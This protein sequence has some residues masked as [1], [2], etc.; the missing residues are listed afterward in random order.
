M[1]K[2]QQKLHRR[3]DR[4][5]IAILIIYLGALTYF[6]AF[7]YLATED[8][9][10]LSAVDFIAQGRLIGRSTG[11]PYTPL[12]GYLYYWYSLGFGASVLGLRLLTGFLVVAAAIPIYL[13]LR[14]ISG[15]AMAF[16]LTLLSYSLSTFPHP[17]LEY[18]IE[19]AFAAY[20]IFYGM[21]FLQRERNIYLY[22]CA[23]FAC[24][25]F[26]SRGHPNSSALLLLLPT[27]LLLVGWIINQRESWNDGCIRLGSHLKN[28]Y[29]YILKNSYKYILANTRAVALILLATASLV[30]L[31]IFLRKV[32]YRR[33]FIEYADVTD[34]VRD[35]ARLD[36]TFWG[37]ILLIC[38][39]AVYLGIPTGNE[40]R[41]S[42][43]SKLRKSFPIF[44]PFVLCGFL[45]M[46]IAAAVG[47]SWQDLLF[48]IFPVDIIAD[49]RAVGR[50]GRRAAGIL[51]AFLAVTATTLYFY[52]IGSL[53]KQRAKISLFLLFLTPA[54]FAR[55]FPT[56]NMLY[57]GV[58]PLAVF[59]GNILPL[60]MRSFGA[61]PG[62]LTKAVSIFFVL[63]SVTSNY[64][65]LVKT[66]L[67]DLNAGRLVKL[68]QQS[69]NGIFVE[70]DVFKLF[71][72]IR[73]RLELRG[74]AQEPKA[75]L[76]SR[77]VKLTPLIYQWTD[78]LAGQ[79]L[80]IQLGKLWSY[81][82]LIK[83]EG[84][85][86]ADIFDWPGLIYRWR[87][88]A[89]DQLKQSHTKVIVMSLYDEEILEEEWE[90]SS[91]PLKE[92]LRQNF[93]V[94]DVIEPTMTLYRRSIFPEGAIIL[95][96]NTWESANP[97]D[98]TQ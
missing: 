29:K 16:A 26:A 71:E 20:A 17:R 57:L 10:A 3:S 6:S 69:V 86:S 90:P 19:G 7:F 75:F 58:F 76:S 27:S 30:W 15:P 33:L 80:T 50:I 36:S 95:R 93:I 9:E 89:V 91:D 18:F 40:T 42:L 78:S 8:Y 34:L 88:A 21:R 59:L 49:H 97:A 23:F 63:Y 25:A 43:A 22:L 24:I 98:R 2:A 73:E 13:T 60:T 5:H 37:W 1:N 51:P 68:D 52:L 55:F 84:V 48:F 61:S 70:E 62:R 56:Y 38:F 81:D 28:S 66:Q 65:L 31:M 14:A 35:S 64:L 82:D 74:L 4:I 67:D 79:N 46:V 53:D 47:Y 54:T 12:A 96:R 41:N 94:S 44:F 39:V 87:E 85:Q 92:Y 32:V 45:M 72:D 83:I 11:W 77:Y